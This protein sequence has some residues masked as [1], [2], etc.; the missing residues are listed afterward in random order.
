MS[1]SSAALTG[2]IMLSASWSVSTSPRKLEA[3]VAMA[4]FVPRKAFA[5]SRMMMMMMSLNHAL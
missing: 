5:V 2:E 4:A 3:I 1:V